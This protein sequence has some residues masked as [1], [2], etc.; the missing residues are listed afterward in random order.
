MTLIRYVWRVLHWPNS[1]FFS[2]TTNQKVSRIGTDSSKWWLNIFITEVAQLCSHLDNSL[3]TYTSAFYYRSYS[4]VFT[5]S[6]EFKNSISMH[7]DHTSYTLIVALFIYQMFG[8]SLKIVSPFFPPFL[9]GLCAF[10]SFNWVTSY[11]SV[12]DS[13]N[14]QACSLDDILWLYFCCVWT[15]V[16]TVLCKVLHSTKQYPLFFKWLLSEQDGFYNNMAA[17]GWH[18]YYGCI[19][20]FS[21]KDKPHHFLEI[22]NDI[23]TLSSMFHLFLMVQPAFNYLSRH[24]NI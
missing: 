14:I 5:S 20:L 6:F 22:A 2:K 10:N 24:P 11:H 19:D 9:L 16:V 23:F 12:G 1:V 21:L 8:I 4:A 15:F 13:I 18:L 7:F 3:D 17:T